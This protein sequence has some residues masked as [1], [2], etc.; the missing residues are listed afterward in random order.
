MKRMP[1]REWL[2]AALMLDFLG[3]KAEG[4]ALRGAVKAAV[5]ENRVTPDLGGELS[6]A[7][8]GDWLCTYLTKNAGRA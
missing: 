1:R 4:D 5:Q 6:T 3:W 2:A 7:A 8:V